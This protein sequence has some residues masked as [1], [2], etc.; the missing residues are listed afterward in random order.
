MIPILRPDTLGLNPFSGM[1]GRSGSNNSHQIPLSSDF[2]P[3][4]SESGFLAVKRYPFHK[5]AD[6]FHWHLFARLIYLI[7]FKAGSIEQNFC[8]R[9]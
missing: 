3:Q 5:P 8:H 4:N 9:V 2:Y 6:G 1:D 7:A